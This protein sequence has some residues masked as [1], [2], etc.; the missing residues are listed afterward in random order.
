MY[1]EIS[2]IITILSSLSANYNYN[3]ET[4]NRKEVHCLAQNIY[5]ESRGETNYGKLAVANVTKNR[6]KSDNYPNTYCNV[7][8]EKKKSAKTGKMVPMFSWTLDGFSDDI[9]L[10]NKQNVESW[11]KSVVISSLVILDEFKDITCGSTHYYAHEK[12]NPYW[13]NSDNLK[14]S[15][16]PRGKIGNHTFMKANQ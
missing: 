4:L 2:I 14:K 7:V 11:K 9:L 13:A 8:W 10:E 12:V 15:C 5:H 3:T 1:S 6:V 16:V